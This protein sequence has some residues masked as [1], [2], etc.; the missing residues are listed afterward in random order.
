MY[1]TLALVI[2]GFAIA[3]F[4]S[5]E[6]AKLFKKIFAVPGMRLVLPLFLLTTLIVYYEEIVFL[7]LS[8]IQSNFHAFSRKLAAM[9]PF[10]KAALALVKIFL[11]VIFS[12]IPVLGLTYW[13]RKKMHQPFNYSYLTSSLIWIFCAILLTIS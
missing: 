2:I 8:F 9:L 12:L 1:A 6:F 3:V 7:G 5:Q 13:M 10:N 4:F 11:L